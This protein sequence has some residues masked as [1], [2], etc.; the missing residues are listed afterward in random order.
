M[1]L[2][3]KC[4]LPDTKENVKFVNGVCT[5]CI[6]YDRRSDVNWTQRVLE[7]QD[8]LDKHRRKDG[9]YDCIIPVSGGKDSHWLVHMMEFVF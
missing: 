7:L 3:K 6:N 9:R 5:A 8:I 2:C 1:R 4:G